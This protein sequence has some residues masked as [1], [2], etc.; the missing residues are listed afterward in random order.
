MSARESLVKYIFEPARRQLEQEKEAAEKADDEEG[1]R[2]P[3]RA[4]KMTGKKSLR[5][6]R[7]QAAP[8]R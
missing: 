1:G 4:K 6:A 2:G 8:V 3:K 5:F 7:P